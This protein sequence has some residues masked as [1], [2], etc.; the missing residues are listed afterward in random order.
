MEDI[1]RKPTVCGGDVNSFIC[2]ASLLDVTF[3]IYVLMS[4]CQKLSTRF[5][6]CREFGVNLNVVSP[7]EAT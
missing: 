4:L 3:K 6:L 1:E 7:I 2:C 5:Q